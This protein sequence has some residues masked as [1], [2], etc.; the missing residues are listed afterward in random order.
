MVRC[1]QVKQRKYEDVVVYESIR[2]S[3]LSMQYTRHVAKQKQV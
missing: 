3:L 1:L 2:E